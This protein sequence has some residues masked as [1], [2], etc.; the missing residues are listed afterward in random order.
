MKARIKV[1]AMEHTNTLIALGWL[2]CILCIFIG[3]AHA[4]V[5]LIGL[6]SYQG[7]SSSSS[8]PLTPKQRSELFSTGLGEVQAAANRGLN[9]N[10]SYQNPAYLAADAPNVAAPKQMGGG[11]YDALE[12][13]IVT[14]REA[15]IYRA[16]GLERKR[17]DD[18]LNTR[19]IY[20]SGLGVD[21]QRKVTE[22]F[23][24]QITAAGAE[25]ATQ[26]YGLQSTDLNALNQWL[27][28]KAGLDQSFSLG[29]A[30][31][32]NSF[33]MENANRQEASTWKPLEFLKSLWND[34]NG[35][36]SVSSTGAGWG[37]K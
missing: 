13:S 19:G 22:Q 9:G 6:L 31:A 35:N 34:S 37:I 12:K 23:L 30:N 21:A 26:R 5:P 25:G 33:N 7:G 1:W 17:V 32:Q 24:P 28:G 15:P 27:L 4:S 20:N 18:E 16:M 2:L 3:H 11:D 36:I 10:Y 8:N 14:S 29:N